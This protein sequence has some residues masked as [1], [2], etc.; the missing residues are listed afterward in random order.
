VLAAVNERMRDLMQQQ[1]RGAEEA[2]ARGVH[3]SA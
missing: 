1:R 3:S 2:A